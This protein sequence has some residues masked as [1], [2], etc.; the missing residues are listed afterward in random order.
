MILIFEL[1]RPDVW[2]VKDGAIQQ[3]MIQLYDIKKEKKA[4][5]EEMYKL[6]E[7]WKPFRTYTTLYLWAWCREN[8][9]KKKSASKK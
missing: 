1:Q 7:P 9:K 6:A 4:L 2:P 5:I 8:L 3:A